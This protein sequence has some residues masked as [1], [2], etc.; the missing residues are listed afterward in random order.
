MFDGKVYGTD[1]AQHAWF[2]SNGID[3]ETVAFKRCLCF[4]ATYKAIPRCLWQNLVSFQ[5]DFVQALEFA[6]YRSSTYNFISRTHR[7]S[8]EN[9]FAIILISATILRLISATD[10]TITAVICK[11]RFQRLRLLR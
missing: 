9:Q 5:N 11:V 6:G 10:M 4:R 2:E 7:A 8:S 3:G 1:V